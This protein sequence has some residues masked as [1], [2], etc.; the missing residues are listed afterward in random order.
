MSM[1]SMPCCSMVFMCSGT[2]RRAR[3]PAMSRGC[4]VLTRPSSIS[5]KPV[6][7]STRVTGMPE[8]L[9]S[10][11]V[12]P[13]EMTVTP[14]SVRPLANDSTPLLLNT[15]ISARLTF[16]VMLLRWTAPGGVDAGSAPPHSPGASLQERGFV[17]NATAPKG[18]ERRRRDG[19]PA[20]PRLRDDAPAP[21]RRGGCSARG[22]DGSTSP[23]VIRTESCTAG[24]TP[25]CTG[26]HA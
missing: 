12:P 17:R 5:G 16:T 19:T 8:S 21:L 9:S 7:S 2:S 10:L 26:G 25:S 6:T 22:R 23:Y 13:V 15:E 4:M 24:C 20:P 3:M 14:M 1:G 11:A 18:A